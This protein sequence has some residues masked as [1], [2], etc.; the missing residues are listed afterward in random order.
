MAYVAGKCIEVMRNGKPVRLKPGDLVP[1]A[2][3]WKNFKVELAFGRIR[4][5]PDSELKTEK[6]SKV[7]AVP[8]STPE[9]TPK[10]LDSEPSDEYK[11]STTKRKRGR[12]PKQKMEE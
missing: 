7:K 1:E 9:P 12:P 2:P 6:K 3:T 11:K 8:K 5:V 10:P 4:E